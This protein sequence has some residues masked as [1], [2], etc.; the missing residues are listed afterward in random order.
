MQLYVS[1]DCERA[2]NRARTG[3]LSILELDVEYCTLYGVRIV[4]IVGTGSTIIECRICAPGTGYRRGLHCVLR[5][6]SE[7]HMEYVVCTWYYCRYRARTAR[8]GS[9]LVL[10]VVLRIAAKA[11][12]TTRELLCP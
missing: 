8:Y 1:T 6:H 10:Y 4:V 11:W 12:P 3:T 7:A 5:H 2:L 9:V